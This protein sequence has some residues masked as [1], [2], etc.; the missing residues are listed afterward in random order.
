[1]NK[2]VVRDSAKDLITRSHVLSLFS[3]AEYGTLPKWSNSPFPSQHTLAPY[4]TFSPGRCPTPLLPTFT[5]PILLP[6]PLVSPKV[7]IAHLVQISSC[8][9]L[10]HILI[11][12]AVPMPWGKVPGSWIFPHP[13]IAFSPA[14]HT[15]CLNEHLP[16]ILCRAAVRLG[17]KGQEWR[18]HC[19]GR[20]WWGW[21]L[22]WSLYESTTYLLIEA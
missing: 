21:P 13:S 15:V 8:L 2:N 16:V 1:M 22:N 12:P 18:V 7:T 3:V 11:S 14:P 4:G 9:C 6:S 19:R 17:G 10:G 5:L 20:P